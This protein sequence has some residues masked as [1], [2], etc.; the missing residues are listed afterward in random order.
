M[1]KQDDFHISAR[2]FA[3]KYKAEELEENSIIIDVRESYEWDMIHLT[4]SRRISLGVLPDH[5]HELNP[6]ETIYLLCAHGIRSIHAANFLLKC[7]FVDVKNVD[8]GIAEVAL[9]LEDQDL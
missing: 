7:G 6:N 5:L 4:K 2:E 1:K 8:G 3:K 9:Y